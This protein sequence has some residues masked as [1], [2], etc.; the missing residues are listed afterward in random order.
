MLNDNGELAAMI[1]WESTAFYPH[2]WIATKPLFSAGF[3]F[4]ACDN[5]S[6]WAFLFS[7][8]L[9]AKGFPSDV[10]LYRKWKAALQT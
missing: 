8:A 4:S 2:F 3:N 10:E 9:E 7:R 5:R 6:G 1:D